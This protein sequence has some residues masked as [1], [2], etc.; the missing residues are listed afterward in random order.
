MRIGAIWR[1]WKELAC[2][3]KPPHGGV[4]GRAAS[5]LGPGAALAG[6][7]LD[8]TLPPLACVARGARTPE[9]CGAKAAPTLATQKARLP[10]AIPD[11]G[12]ERLPASPGKA[13]RNDATLR[14][15]FSSN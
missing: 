5:A 7:E 1:P 13:H 6:G 15:P 10:I 2:S 3:P 11:S 8:V 14:R 9:P 12:E 4:F